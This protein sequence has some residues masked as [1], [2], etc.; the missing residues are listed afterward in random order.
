MIITTSIIPTFL[1]QVSSPAQV[2]AT[3]AFLVL[4]IIK[5]EAAV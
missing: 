3:M 5:A 4:L 2:E 1:T